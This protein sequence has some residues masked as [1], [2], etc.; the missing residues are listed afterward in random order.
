VLDVLDYAPFELELV[1]SVAMLE[2]K[3]DYYVVRYFHDIVR[4]TK[5]SERVNV[6]PGTGAG[7]LD[8]VI[9]LYLAWGRNFVVLLDSDATGN[10]ERQRYAARFGPLVENRLISLAEASGK[11]EVKSI[12]SL[13]TGADCKAFQAIVDSRATKFDK[14]AFAREAFR[15]RSR[16]DTQSHSRRRQRGILQRLSNSSE[17]G[18]AHSPRGRH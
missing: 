16:S 9:Q 18:Y 8:T 15:R 14:K 4:A 7:S 6:L 5:Q 17:R 3:T 12:E 2:G 11:A 1:P 13:L 10:R